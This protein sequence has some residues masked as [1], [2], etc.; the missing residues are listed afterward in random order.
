M[1]KILIGIVIIVNCL[2]ASCTGIEEEAPRPKG[3][4]M[5]YILYPPS[6]LNAQERLYLEER[7]AEYRELFNK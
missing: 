1:K 5:D 2:M 6:E 4:Q 7:E 3:V